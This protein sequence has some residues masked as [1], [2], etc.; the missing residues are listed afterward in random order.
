MQ[1]AELCTS[2]R[3][4]SGYPRPHS[5]SPK[6][7]LTDKHHSG[8]ALPWFFTI[9]GYQPAGRHSNL[10]V[11]CDNCSG[12]NKNQFVMQCL[13]LEGDGWLIQEYL[14]LELL[15]KRSVGRKLGVLKSSRWWRA[16]LWSITVSWWAH[17]TVKSVY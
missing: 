16:Q 9:M 4:R 17:R 13:C 10:H 1:C 14:V 7:L 5:S 2:I 15:S 11:H 12:Q 6:R 3:D 8:S